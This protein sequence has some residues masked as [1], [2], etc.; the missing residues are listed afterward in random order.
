MAAF[1]GNE[2]YGKCLR[3]RVRSLGGVQRISWFT[4]SVRPNEKKKYIPVLDRLIFGTQPGSDVELSRVLGRQN[5]F[6]CNAPAF[7]ELKSRTQGSQIRRIGMQMLFDVLDELGTLVV[8]GECATLTATQG[9]SPAGAC[10]VES[11]ISSLI[12]AAENGDNAAADTLFSTLYSDLSY[13]G[14]RNGN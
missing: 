2:A 8:T 1:I 12:G 13:T 10:R 5:T 6:L 4:R 9:E 11:T 14:W 3:P 7:K